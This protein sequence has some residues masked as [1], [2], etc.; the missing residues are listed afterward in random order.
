MNN[1]ETIFFDYFF[2]FWILFMVGIILFAPAGVW[3]RLY[4][5]YKLVDRPSEDPLRKRYGA[6][7]WLDGT[8]LNGMLIVKFYEQYLTVDTWSP[9]LKPMFFRYADMALHSKKIMRST[10]K[11]KGIPTLG[12]NQ[13][14]CEF[15]QEQINKLPLSPVR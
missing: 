8:Q 3:K 6:S 1:I 14:D 9:F 7:L 2:V 12:F 11:V 13:Y 5:K 4:E 10:F 15:I